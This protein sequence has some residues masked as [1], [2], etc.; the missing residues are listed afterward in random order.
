MDLETFGGVAL[1]AGVHAATA[2]VV[3]QVLAAGPAAV[4]PPP[5]LGS[6]DAFVGSF[7]LLLPR[8]P[9]WS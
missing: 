5:L 2:A 6:A 4:G 1:V 9:R 7:D 8:F 3:L